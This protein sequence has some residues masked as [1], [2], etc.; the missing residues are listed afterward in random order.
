MDKNPNTLIES[1]EPIESTE[2]HR[3]PLPDR[4][5]NG[6]F[7]GA[8]YEA[9]AHLMEDGMTAGKA[10]QALGDVRQNGYLIAKKIDQRYDLT[11]PKNIKLAHDADVKILK[12]FL[13][14]DKVKLP[15]ELK[16][17]DVNRSIDRRYDR[18][19]PVKRDDAGPQ[20]ISFTQV[21]LYRSN[22]IERDES[23]TK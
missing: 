18:Y 3:K 8:K 4:A 10:A 17:S 13:Y 19:Q 2:S 22:E 1:I 16:T 5:K 20:S 7:I 9:F 11:N 14:P 12:A 23:E 15:C 6:R 21:N